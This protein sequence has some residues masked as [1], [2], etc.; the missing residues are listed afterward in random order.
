MIRDYLFRY[1]TKI[2]NDLSQDIEYIV[3]RQE[4]LEKAIEV[5]D[6]IGFENFGYDVY[7]VDSIPCF[8]TNPYVQK[9]LEHLYRNE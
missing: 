9:Q 4:S 2:N 1:I 7:F 3:L 5:F 6:E 8:S